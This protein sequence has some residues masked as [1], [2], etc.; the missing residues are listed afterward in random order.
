M[1][2]QATADRSKLGPAW[3]EINTRAEELYFE[4]L[5]QEYVDSVQSKKQ[6]E[7]DY[8]QLL[9]RIYFDSDDDVVN[10]VI[11]T[12]SLGA[13]KVMIVY[14][15]FGDNTRE[16]LSMY[17]ADPAEVDQRFP[18]RMLDKHLACVKTYFSQSGEEPHWHYVTFGLSDL[19][20]IEEAPDASDA[21]SGCGFELTMRVLALPEEKA[22]PAWPL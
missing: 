21:G 13:D 20:A 18:E 3:E 1:T 11:D 15:Q 17:G 10:Y 5:D 9:K 7:L 12:I 19:Y 14:Y 4:P 8:G 22:P 16:V 6:F 2:N